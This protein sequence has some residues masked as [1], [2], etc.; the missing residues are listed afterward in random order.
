MIANINTTPGTVG[1]RIAQELPKFANW[2]TGRQKAT[3]EEARAWF[4]AQTGFL[5]SGRI[6]V[7]Q[8]VEAGIIAVAGD[9]VRPVK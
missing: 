8:A 6:G 3:T 1:G 5:A 2:I 4:I 7:R 9:R